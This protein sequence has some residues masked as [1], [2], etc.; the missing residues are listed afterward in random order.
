VPDATFY[1]SGLIQWSHILVDPTADRALSIEEFGFMHNSA[2]EIVRISI[3]VILLYF[4]KDTQD[5]FY[6]TKTVNLSHNHSAIRFQ[7]HPGKKAEII[8]QPT[9]HPRR[10]YLKTQVFNTLQKI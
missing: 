4:I 6:L 1:E 3:P 10:Q 9:L 7:D 8:E 5:R 2:I